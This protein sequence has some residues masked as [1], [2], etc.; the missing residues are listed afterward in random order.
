MKYVSLCDGI[1][2]AH[3]AFHPLGWECVGISEI[4]PFCNAVIA[5]HYPHIKNFGDLTSDATIKSIK[6][7]KPDLIIGGTPCQSFS[8]AGNQEGLSDEIGR[9]HV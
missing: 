5:Q 2:A 1:G 6:K 9:A 8:L 7:A 3:V 4:N